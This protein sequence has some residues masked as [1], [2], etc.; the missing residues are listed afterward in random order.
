MTNLWEDFQRNRSR[1]GFDRRI[2]AQTGRPLGAQ[3]MEKGLGALRGAIG[4]PAQI[5][6][7]LRGYADAGVDQVIFVAQAGRNRHEH[8]CESM[9]LFAREVMPAFHEGEAERERKKVERLAPAIE[10]ALARRAPLRTADPD[11]VMR[12]A[13]KA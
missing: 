11:Y 8:I 5:R 7:L 1:F 9:E 10:A 4:T 12:A 3:I 6:E 2:A 13:M